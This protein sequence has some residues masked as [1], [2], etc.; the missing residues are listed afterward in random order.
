FAP[1]VLPPPRSVRNAS[2]AGVIAAA[3]GPAPDRTNWA[4][5]IDGIA[6]SANNATEV[7]SGT[8]NRSW[9]RM[10]TLLS[11]IEPETRARFT[12][13]REAWRPPFARNEQ[14]HHP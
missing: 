12:P 5:T 11:L 9:L 6:P 8:V 14:R 2:R 10:A 3:F 7:I 13:L 1:A 4:A